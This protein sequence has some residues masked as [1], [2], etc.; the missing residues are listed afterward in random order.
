MT[1]STMCAVAQSKRR[2]SVVSI[3]PEADSDCNC[4]LGIG[5]RS[6]KETGESVQRLHRA[7]SEGR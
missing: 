4:V 7:K 5:Q 6:G 3:D 2:S 1:S